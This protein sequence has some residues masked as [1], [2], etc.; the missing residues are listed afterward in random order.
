MPQTDAE[1]LTDLLGDATSAS[2]L[3]AGY[4]SIAE[5]ASASEG[6]IESRLTPA[7]ARRVRAGLELAKRA[8]LPRAKRARITLSTDA[9]AI[10][11]PAMRSLAHESFRV[12]LLSARH[13]ALGEPIE[14]AHGGLTTCSVLPREVFAPAIVR[15]APALILAHNHPSGDPTPSADDLTLTARL[16]QAGVIL[17]IKVLDHLTIGDGR[18]ESLVDAGQWASL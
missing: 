1:L 6:T 9:Y 11:G 16:K 14:I 10:L 3:L 13:E 8:S 4:G 15:G 12:L 7:R 18:Y 17:G 5:L 2:E